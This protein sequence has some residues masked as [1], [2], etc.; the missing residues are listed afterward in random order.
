MYNVYFYL[1][2]DLWATITQTSD[3][4][5]LSLVSVYYH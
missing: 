2:G 5:D 3:T 4:T 1:M